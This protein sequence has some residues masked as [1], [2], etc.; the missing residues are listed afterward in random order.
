MVETTVLESTRELLVKAQSTVDER[1]EKKAKPKKKAAPKAKAKPK[2]RKP[3]AAK[4]PASKGDAPIRNYDQLSAKDVVAR[5]QRL[6]GP[7]ATAVLDYER[8]R[9]KRA[10]VIRAVEKRLSAAS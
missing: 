7:Q 9:K 10:T 1:I 2:A 5:V 8:S 6:S 3:K 4:A